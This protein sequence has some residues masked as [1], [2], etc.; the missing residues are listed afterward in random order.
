MIAQL[1]ILATCI[2]TKIVELSWSFDWVR[3]INL[4]GNFKRDA[5]GINGQWPIKPLIVDEGDLLVIHATNLLNE[6]SSLHFHGLFQNGTAAFDGAIGITDCGIAPNGGKYT[7]RVNTAG[8]HGTYWIHSHYF[9]QYPD[10]LRFP[11]I[12]KDSNDPY[13]QDYQ[14][15]EV[16]LS[17][18]DWYQEY[19]SVLFARNFSKPGANPN[20]LEPL[21]TIPL[22]SDAVNTTIKIKA[23]STYKFRFVSMAT[24]ASF[25]VWI[26]GDHTMSIVEVDG[27]DTEEY[28][29]KV[30]Q[31]A[32]AQRYAVLITAM[33]N[34]TSN[35]VLHYNF[36]LSMFSQEA[37]LIPP[38]FN[39]YGKA[40]LE[41]DPSFPV[42]EPTDPEPDAS[43]FDDL[44]IK[45]LEAMNPIAVTQEVR[46]DGSFALF[47]DSVNHGS[48]NNTPYER[49]LV[50]T[51]LTVLTTGKNAT[52]PQT[53]GRYTS[54]S[55]LSHMEGIQIVLVNKDS[56]GM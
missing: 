29:T 40:V 48:F 23:G 55:I 36:D 37:G 38:F 11:L 21:P 1:F 34:A 50:P 15:R 5:I 7:Y 46:I 8:Q 2:S 18:S 16:I 19:Y 10:G 33:A 51:L 22:L 42:F 3:D 6:T 27:I 17:L 28:D 25:Q 13:K 39:P 32:P 30:L 9:G 45:P 44:Q 14:D 41:Y 47:N 52:N 24:F 54:S 4:D 26:D 49:P 43:L 35:F 12:I 31:I 56:E 20:G 53:Y